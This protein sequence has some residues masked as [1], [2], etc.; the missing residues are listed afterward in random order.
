MKRPAF[1]SRDEVEPYGPVREEE[2]ELER[3]E[4][5]CRSRIRESLNFSRAAMVG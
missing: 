2:E 3:E 1:S 4:R 5:E